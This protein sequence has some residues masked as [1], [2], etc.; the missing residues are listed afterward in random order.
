MRYGLRSEAF[1]GL[2][3]EIACPEA[4]PSSKGKIDGSLILRVCGLIGKMTKSD[5]EIE[6]E[7]YARG[8]WERQLLLQ[9]R[10]EIVVGPPVK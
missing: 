10:K 4:A 2:R 7:E 6:R 1:Q 3:W 9:A 8:Q 5:D